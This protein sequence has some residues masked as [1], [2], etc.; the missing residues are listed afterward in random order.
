MLLKS[1]LIELMY[2]HLFLHIRLISL[3]FY[4]I[5][6]SLEIYWIWSRFEI[7]HQCHIH[8]LAVCVIAVT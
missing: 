4:L 6:T 8:A 1:G 5:I 2:V 7:G 3:G